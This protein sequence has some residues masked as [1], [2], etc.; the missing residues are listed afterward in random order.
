M[1]TGPS[2]WSCLSGAFIEMFLQKNVRS[3]YEALVSTC[4]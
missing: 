4:L 3:L 1:L 2:S